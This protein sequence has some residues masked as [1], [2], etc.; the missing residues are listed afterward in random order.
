MERFRK[1]RDG[2]WRRPEVMILVMAGA[3]PFGFATWNALLNNF[4][5]ERA[6]FTGAE[7]GILQSL[8]EVPGFMAFAAVFILILMREQTL[9]IVSLL[10][11]GIGTALTGWFPSVIGLYCTTVLMSIGYHYYA[12][13]QTSLTLQWTAPEKTPEM[14]GRIVAVGSAT[15]IV[16]FGIIWLAFDFA[17]LDFRW[18]YMIG[19]GITAVAALVCW[20]VYPRFPLGVKQHRHLVIRRRYWLFYLLSFMGGARRQIFI[21]FAGFLMVEK[22]GFGVEDITLLFLL[23]AAINMWLAPRIGRFVARWGERRALILEY[24]G[25]IGVFVGYALV[26]NAALAA[27]LYVVDHLFFALALAINSYFQ[28]IA[29][30][31]DIASTAGV[32]FSIDHTAAVS[33]PV[34]LGFLWLTSPAMVF[35]IGAAMAAFSLLLALNVP[36]RPS[37]GNETLF[38]FARKPLPE[39]L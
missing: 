15:S 36:R 30:A 34:V 2:G 7:I 28:K 25:L 18:I 23:N 6:G 1:L 8:R 17:A 4:V 5:I 29:D 37:P 3:V 33:V 26:E 32:S 20:I 24:L 27:G 12:T 19:G 39:R 31:A 22:F 21:V 38:S 35:L 14:L 10:L 11:L 13:R 16:T 9:A